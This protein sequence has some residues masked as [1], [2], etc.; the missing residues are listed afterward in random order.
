KTVEEVP[1]NP[2][3]GTV[4]GTSNQETEKPVQPAE[5]STTNSEKV[6]P[7]T[8]SENTGEESSNPSDS[9]TSVGESNKPEHNDSKN[10]NS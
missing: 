10:E 5:E 3:E 9:T 4:E 7:D 8:S 6:S 2:N 1:V